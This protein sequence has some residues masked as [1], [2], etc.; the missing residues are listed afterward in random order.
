MP[1]SV[2]SWIASPFNPG[3]CSSMRD[4]AG[5]SCDYVRGRL[6][7]NPHRRAEIARIVQKVS[8]RPLTEPDAKADPIWCGARLR[9]LQF[10]RVFQADVWSLATVAAS[11][12]IVKS[13]ATPSPSKSAATASVPKRRQATTRRGKSFVILG[14]KQDRIALWEMPIEVFLSI[15]DRAGGPFVG[16][17]GRDIP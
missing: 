3:T 15:G 4:S 6:P 11:R 2:S 12:V 14:A 13:S 9:L 16:K 10:P 8:P 5:R 17:H 7:F 1:A